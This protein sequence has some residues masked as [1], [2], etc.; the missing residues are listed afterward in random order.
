[1][2]TLTTFDP[3]TLLMIA[4]L[5]PA[6]IAVGF[7][8]GYK[9]DQWQKLIVAALAAALA[10][11]LLFLVAVFVGLIKTASIGGESGIVAM[12]TIFGFAWAVLGYVLAR[13]RRVRG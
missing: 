1:M 9:A 7:L 2:M 8:M 5:N 6:V 12:Q 4:A 3:W 10:G 11:F 13:R